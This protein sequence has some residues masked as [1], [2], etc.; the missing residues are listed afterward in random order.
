M[1]GPGGTGK[2]DAVGRP[3]PASAHFSVQLCFGLMTSFLSLLVR[4]IE[5][6]EEALTPFSV[7]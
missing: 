1:S 3:R 7:I 2:R 5:N 6:G 4:D